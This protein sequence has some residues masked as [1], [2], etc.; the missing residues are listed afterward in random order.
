MLLLSVAGNYVEMMLNCQ[1]SFFVK[2]CCVVLVTVYVFVFFFNM[3]LYSAVLAR[4][5]LK[6]RF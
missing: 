5:P 4:T 1:M 2:C 6:K 3:E